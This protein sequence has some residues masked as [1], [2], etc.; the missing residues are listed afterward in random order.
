M[1]CAGQQ[2]AAT[3]NEARLMKGAGVEGEGMTSDALSKL[4]DGASVLFGAGLDA[5]TYVT[6]AFAFISALLPTELNAYGALDSAK[7]ELDACFD[8]YPAGLGAS[9]EAY[10]MLMHKYEPF[11]FDPAVN[12]GRPYSARDFFTRAKFHDLDIF[13][14]VYAPMRYEDHCFVHV[15]AE[16][17]TTVFFGLFRGGDFGE[18]DKQL[19]A[20]AQPH[21]IDARR[22]AQA[23]TANKGRSATPAIFGRAGFTPRESEILYWLIEEKTNQEIADLLHVPIDTVHSHLRSLYEKM[24]VENRVAATLSALALM[25]QI[26]MPAPFRVT[27]TGGT[28]PLSAG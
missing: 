11:R 8:R 27:A 12:G 5:T 2:R 17:G 20:L 22:L 26:V 15:P 16:R 19:L 14:E 7:G 4:N 24:G 25:R 18:R 9:L 23:H 3:E 10:G 6:R 1:D 21:L 28:D 13:Q